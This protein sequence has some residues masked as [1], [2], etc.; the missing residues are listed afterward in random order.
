MT[1]EP[2]LSR[3]TTV[4]RLRI[5]I[6]HQAL[7]NLPLVGLAADTFTRPQ[8]GID[9]IWS[10]NH[11]MRV[12]KLACEAPHRIGGR[13]ARAAPEACK[14]ILERRRQW[15]EPADRV[16]PSAPDSGE[17]KT[18]TLADAMQLAAFVHFADRQHIESPFR[19]CSAEAFAQHFVAES[20]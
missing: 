10:R 12:I 14:I 16:F 7:A 5:G 20:A 4:A 19:G 17:I 9:L 8:E 6:I 13:F 11:L 18:Q 2:S 15:N 3:E 1:A